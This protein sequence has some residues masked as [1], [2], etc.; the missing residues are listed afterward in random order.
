MEQLSMNKNRPKESIFNR[1]T[2]DYT[3]DSSFIMQIDRFNQLTV[4]IY[5]IDL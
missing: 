2:I 5:G 4:K 1:A 3:K